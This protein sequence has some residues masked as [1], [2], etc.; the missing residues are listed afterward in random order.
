MLL[1]N[2]GSNSLS[3]LIISTYK[4]S[5]YASFKFTLS[6][7]VCAPSTFL[8]DSGTRSCNNFMLGYCNFAFA[9]CSAIEFSP[10]VSF[11]MSALIPDL[12]CTIK[13]RNDALA[14]LAILEKSSSLMNSCLSNES[15][16]SLVISVNCSCSSLINEPTAFIPRSINLF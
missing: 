4:F 12:V 1:Y 3:S 15:N 9:N 5:S 7:I 10:V 13:S 8:D 2:S 11:N 14:L 16:T 6:L